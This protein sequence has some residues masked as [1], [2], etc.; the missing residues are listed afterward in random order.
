MND[1]KR[2]AED[3]ETCDQLCAIDGGLTAWE[4]DFVESVTAQVE[5]GRELTEKQR[6]LAERLLERF[7]R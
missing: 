4:I 5:A 2:L 3:S 1:M 6:D 7:G